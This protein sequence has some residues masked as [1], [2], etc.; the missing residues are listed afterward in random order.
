[1]KGVDFVHTFIRYALVV[2]RI[3]GSTTRKYN[4]IIY[5]S[6]IERFFYG[7]HTNHGGLLQNI[8]QLHWTTE[9]KTSF[10]GS[11]DTNHDSLL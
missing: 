6:N 2:V 1:M 7:F 3:N 8:L 5:N 11:F 10:L 9:F 4:R